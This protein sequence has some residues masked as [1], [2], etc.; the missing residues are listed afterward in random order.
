[1]AIVVTDEMMAGWP[2]EA[3]AVVRMLQQQIDELRAGW[4][5]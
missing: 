1:M 3:R 4:Q 2:P 5:S